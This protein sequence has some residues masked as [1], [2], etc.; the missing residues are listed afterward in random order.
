M[1]PITLGIV[2]LF[3]FLAL[4][5]LTVEHQD[6]VTDY[7][8]PAAQL[9]VRGES[10]Y[11]INDGERV[12]LYPPTA[13]IAFL[14]LAFIG[15]AYEVVAFLSILALI[16]LIR[17]Q[18]ADWTWLLYPPALMALSIGQTELIVLA[19]GLLAY[20]HR[21]RPWS[22][23]VMAS[24]CLF[25]PHIGLFWMI[26]FVATK[27]PQ[28]AT[29]A[30]YGGV[31]LLGVC[32]SWLLVPGWWT[33]WWSA[34]GQNAVYYQLRGQS[35]VTAGLPWLALALVPA[36]ILLARDEKWARVLYALASPVTSFQAG[37]GLIGAVPGGFVALSWLLAGVALVTRVQ[38]FWIEP[39]AM[40]AWL[41]WPV[42]Q[43]FRLVQRRVVRHV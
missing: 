21:D 40:L 43:R 3:A 23:V 28:I 4:N 14:P 5:F 29:V 22:D 9:L 38:M 24:I 39:V 25:K 12:F 37:A 16:Y 8:V 26:P 15:P 31:I 32:V 41:A 34:M 35:L 2:C 6:D 18:K 7:Y 42:V 36:L 20:R 10:P 17:A 1:K 11:A 30:R 27:T 13:L 19:L 33:E